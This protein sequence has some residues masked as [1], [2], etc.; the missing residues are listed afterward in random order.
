MNTV[1]IVLAEDHQIVRQGLKV[2]LEAEADFRVVGQAGDGV[3]AVRMVEKIRPNVLV[4][5]LRLPGLSGLDVVRQV[6]KRAP[7]TKIVILSMYANEAYVLAS[8][9]S[10]AAGY[11]LKDLSVADLVRAV[12]EA[13]AGRRYLSP[14]L[15]ERAIEAYAKKADPELSDFYDRLTDREREVVQLAAHGHTN[16]E[17]GKRLFI[18]PRTVEI[19][20]AN[21]MHKLGLRSR[22]D[23][24]RYMFQRGILPMDPMQDPAEEKLEG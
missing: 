12:R 7:D 5:D 15:T 23:L 10:G 9:R 4:L 8:L 21:A 18:S 11:V 22:V 13:L 6:H 1:N 16:V 24:V 14:P 2:L 3:E 20:R 17:I 19:H